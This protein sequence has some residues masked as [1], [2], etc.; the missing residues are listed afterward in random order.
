MFRSSPFHLHAASV[1][2]PSTP[3]PSDDENII[4]AD[5]DRLRHGR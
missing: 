4:K 5:G 3:L 1:N 2:T